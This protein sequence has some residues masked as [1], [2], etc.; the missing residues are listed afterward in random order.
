[1]P[2]LFI[3]ATGTDVGKTFIA[4]ALIRA[5]KAEGREVGAFKPVL[6]G[7]EGIEGSDA[8]RLMQALG[9]TDLDRM[10]PLRFIAPLAPPSAARLEGET[11]TLDDL[12][13]RCV[14]RLSDEEWKLTLIEGAGGLMSPL[15][16]DGANLDLIQRL[17]LP[18]ILVSGSYLGSISH[19]FTAIEVLLTRG[20]ALRAVVISQSPGDNPPLSEM[21]NA[22][23]QYYPTIPVVVV[24]RDD[25]EA[26][27]ALA[28]H[29]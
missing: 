5:L 22:M 9:E 10:S 8:G 18:S 28:A 7:F 16:E 24:P 21:T 2:G 11:L 4:C 12:A 19:T 23:Q 27:W 17:Q 14:A 20:L 13:A 29:V 15:A 3:T 26:A 25:E 6:S 1:M